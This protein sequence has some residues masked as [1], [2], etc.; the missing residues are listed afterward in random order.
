MPMAAVT[1]YRTTLTTSD[2]GPR[3]PFR[4]T[5]LSSLRVAIPRR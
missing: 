2:F 5:G 1:L 3:V 4:E